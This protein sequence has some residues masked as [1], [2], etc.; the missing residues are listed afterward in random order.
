MPWC[1]YWIPAVGGYLRIACPYRHAVQTRY[2]FARIGMEF[3]CRDCGDY[4]TVVEV[5]GMFFF[6][7]GFF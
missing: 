7:L 3:A 4:F 1:E 6:F 5:D 2:M